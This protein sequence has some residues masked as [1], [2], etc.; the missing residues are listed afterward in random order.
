MTE[1]KTRFLKRCWQRRASR[2]SASAERGG[3]PGAA[4]GF[5]VDDAAGRAAAAARGTEVVGA[6]L[7]VVAPDNDGLG[8]AAVDWVADELG[9]GVLV[10]VAASRD[11][12]GNLD[13]GVG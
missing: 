10:V 7:T 13:V 8:D 4:T 2:A 1:D 3:G 12:G 5:A 11:A 6:G 9:T